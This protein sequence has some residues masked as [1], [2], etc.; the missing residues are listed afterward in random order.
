MGRSDVARAVGRYL[1]RLRR[2]A[3]LSLARVVDLLRDDGVELDP[4]TLSRA[5][6]GDTMLRLDV[7]ELVTERLGGTLEELGEVIREAR[8]GLVP[9]TATSARD[10]ETIRGEVR[11]L[12]EDGAVHDGLRLA[13]S[14]VE[15][16]AGKDPPPVSPEV[17][18]SIRI[19]LADAYRR[20]G[21]PRLS[22]RLLEDVL[23]TAQVSG[24]D[25]IRALLLY[26]A[27]AE[28]IGD[29]LRADLYA[30][31]VASL[32]DESEG[33][34][35]LAWA[36]FV[37]G[38]TCASSGDHERAA[39]WYVESLRHY[40]RLGRGRQAAHVRV[41][42]AETFLALGDER[43]ARELLRDAIG[44]AS[45]EGWHAIELQARKL[46]ADLLLASGNHRAARA[47]YHRVAAV[48]RRLDMVNELFLARHGLWRIAELSGDQ[49]ARR[50]EAVSLRRLLPRVDP[51]L[52]EA[53][54][55]RARR[56]A[57]RRER[58]R[59][60]HA[61]RTGARVPHPS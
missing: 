51:R 2:E 25:R 37:I 15:A 5:E 53:R 8:A 19:D 36:C 30:N 61:A 40:E 59:K 14:L 6:R 21:M 17:V 39:A 18:A 9:I 26:V 1:A 42:L 58:A 24:E 4:S 32:L 43:R 34:R 10:V 27:A 55:F 33:P 52:V 11:S 12:L 48:A 49:E 13:R 60:K 38:T 7:A 29:H 57:T 44:A 47:A 46:M 28:M 16:L 50:R 56:N 20:C 45:R 54:E 35:L 41:V 31:H 23:N 3:G 22:A